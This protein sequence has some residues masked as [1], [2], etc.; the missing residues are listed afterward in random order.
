MDI[1][2]SLF[3]LSTKDTPYDSTKP[4]PSKLRNKYDAPADREA[5]LQSPMLA[6]AAVN[7]GAS[8]LTATRLDVL[9]GLTELATAAALTTPASRQRSTCPFCVEQ[10]DD[11]LQHLIWECQFDRHAT[12]TDRTF[13]SEEMAIGFA[14]DSGPA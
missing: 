9:G 4:W 7:G 13:N 3:Y 6:R 14:N 8:H 2:T 11:S 1:P 12:A 10:P 5:L